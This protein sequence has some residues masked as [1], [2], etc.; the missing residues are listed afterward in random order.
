MELSLH[1]RSVLSFC[2]ISLCLPSIFSLA[3]S[4]ILASL[5]ASVACE[6][7]CPCQGI[8]LPPPLALSFDAQLPLGTRSGPLYPLLCFVFCPQELLHYLIGTLLLLIASIVTASKSYN[9]S[10]VVAGAVR[11]LSGSLEQ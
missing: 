7:H 4:F 3:P 11:M 2:A 1:R 6:L 10:G 9:Q 5:L 8:I